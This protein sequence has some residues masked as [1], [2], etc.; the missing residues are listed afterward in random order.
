MLYQIEWIEIVIALFSNFENGN[1]TVF[2]TETLS[3]SILTDALS[4]LDISLIFYCGTVNLILIETT[5]WTAKL[6]S[7]YGEAVAKK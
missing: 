7:A 5:F 4:K 3:L 2:P 1:L 6:M